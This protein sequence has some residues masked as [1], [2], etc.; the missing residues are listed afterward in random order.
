MLI[1]GGWRRAG[2]VPV[3]RLLSMYDFLKVIKSNAVY[4]FTSQDS[5]PFRKD[6]L[7]NIYDNAGWWWWHR[8]TDW[9]NYPPKNQP[10]IQLNNQFRGGGFFY[11]LTLRKRK[12]ISKPTTTAWRSDLEIVPLSTHPPP[13]WITVLLQ[14]AENTLNKAVSAWLAF[15]GPTPKY[16]APVLLWA[17]NYIYSFNVV[18]GVSGISG[19]HITSSNNLITFLSE[20]SSRRRSRR[21]GIGFVGGLGKAQFCRSRKIRFAS[22]CYYIFQINER[23]PKE[24]I[25]T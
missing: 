2:V 17:P 21:R 4:L 10:T 20:H 9:E 16:R 12:G 24:D 19:V 7:K 8:L 15:P 5:T 14:K 23:E 3:A 1:P 18:V 13:L 11:A 6:S 25:F 22:N